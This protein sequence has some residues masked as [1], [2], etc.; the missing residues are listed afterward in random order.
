MAKHL[1][2][3]NK[4]VLFQPLSISMD[5]YAKFPDLKN[6]NYYDFSMNLNSEINLEIKQELFYIF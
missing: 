3:E 5:S 1:F 4:W 2:E 6:Y